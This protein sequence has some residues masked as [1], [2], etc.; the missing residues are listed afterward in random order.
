MS[1]YE[2][3]VKLACKPKAAPPKAKV[4]VLSSL[5]FFFQCCSKL[6]EAVH[7]QYLDTILAATWS[8][9]GAVHDVCKAL[10]PRFREPNAIV[11]LPGNVTNEGVSLTSRHRLYSK[12]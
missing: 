4:C 7:N 5:V 2:K 10:S 9:D 11:R 6:I 8:E 3:V 1:T 12:H